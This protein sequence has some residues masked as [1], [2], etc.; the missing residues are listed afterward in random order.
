MSAWATRLVESHRLRRSLMGVPFRLGYPWAMRLDERSWRQSDESH[1]PALGPGRDELLQVRMAW[2]TEAYGPSDVPSL[3]RG[4]RGLGL[5]ESRWER[6]VGDAV[7][8]RRRAAGGW[9]SRHLPVMQRAGER[10]GFGDIVDAELPPGVKAAQPS[11]IMLPGSISLL[12]FSF[13]YEEEEATRVDRVMRRDYSTRGRMTQSGWTFSPP[14]MVQR[15]AVRSCLAEQRKVLESWLARHVPGAFARH[16]QDG[17]PGARLLTYRTSEAM[18][19]KLPEAEWSLTIDAPNELELWASTVHQELGL[20]LGERRTE[21]QRLLRLVAPESKIRPV[22]DERG[23]Q[24]G[25]DLGW[26]LLFQQMQRI[27][28]QTLVVHSAHE[29]LRL[30]TA[31]LADVRDLAAPRSLRPRRAALQLARVRDALELASDARSVAAD[32]RRDPERLLYVSYD[33]ADWS[34][35]SDH[36][37]GEPLTR[38]LAE[39]LSDRAEE[40]LSQELRVRE[41]L[42]IESQLFAAGAGLRVQ[43]AAFWIATLALV[44]SIAAVLLALAQVLQARS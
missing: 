7:V 19:V 31:R 43:R 11:I 40:T 8:E 6:S 26:W 2:V 33:G 34:P 44:A 3:L 13:L 23:E 37:G 18:E 4:L 41:R 14:R 28:G 12:M 29:L 24:V 27:V 1:W 16:S 22:A 5:D 42:D 20:A 9:A 32:L 10:L 39:T 35:S 30:Y 15:D 38:V 17:H 21:S 36:R 25:D